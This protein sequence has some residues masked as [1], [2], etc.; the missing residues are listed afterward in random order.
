MS[1]DS[2]K[3]QKVSEDVRKETIPQSS[4]Q[5]QTVEPVIVEAQSIDDPVS[6]LQRVCEVHLHH[7]T[8]YLTS[9]RSRL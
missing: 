3:R 1:I 9:T 4:T 2:P 5:S 8:I 7:L 6:L